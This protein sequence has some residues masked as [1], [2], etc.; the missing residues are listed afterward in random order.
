MAIMR[1]IAVLN[2]V[3]GLARDR[4]INTFHFTGDATDNTIREGILN[5]VRDFYFLVPPNVIKSPAMYLSDNMTTLDCYLYEIPGTLTAGG[6]ETPAGAPI[7]TLLGVTN[8]LATVVKE[9]QSSLPQE[10]AV[11]VSVQGTPGP[12]MI[13]RR[14]RGGI[15]FGPLNYGA[16]SGDNTPS[17]PSTG[18][19][20][21]L[22]EAMVDLAKRVDPHAEMVVYSRPYA[23]RDEFVG[24]N[25]RTYPAL[26]PRP[27]TTV[28]IDEVWVDDEFDTQRRRGLVRTGRTLVSTGEA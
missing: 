14:R 18:V 23:G 10:V 1:A 13:Q 11:K 24:Q 5:E 20:N 26:D 9:S 7:E 17:R 6:R 21:V 2:H 15:F 19:R 28:N 3:S 4:C 25:G 12:G 22:V 8:D 16:N 27:A